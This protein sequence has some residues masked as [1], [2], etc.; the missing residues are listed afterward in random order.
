MTGKDI[1]GLKM[2]GGLWDSIDPC[3]TMFYRK[4]VTTLYPSAANSEVCSLTSSEA[5]TIACSVSAHSAEALK[6]NTRTS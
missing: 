3:K 2:E 1:E 6:Q 5:D 4:H